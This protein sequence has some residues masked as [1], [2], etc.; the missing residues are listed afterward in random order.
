MLKGPEE[1]YRLCAAV[2]MEGRLLTFESAA[3]GLDWFKMRGKSKTATIITIATTT[4]ASSPDLGI[5]DI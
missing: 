4:M 5:I 1:L 3:F 2:N